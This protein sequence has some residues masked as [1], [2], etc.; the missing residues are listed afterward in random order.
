MVKTRQT[1]STRGE[2]RTDARQLASDFHMLAM[3]SKRA[4]TLHKIVSTS[5]F[6]AFTIEKKNDGGGVCC[7]LQG[8]S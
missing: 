3:T 7:H 2:E 8:T 5:G 1:P 4:L 6:L